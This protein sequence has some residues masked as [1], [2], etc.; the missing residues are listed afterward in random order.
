MQERVK[1]DAESTKSNLGARDIKPPPCVSAVHEFMPVLVPASLVKKLPPT[2]VSALADMPAMKDAKMEDVTEARQTEYHTFL[3]KIVQAYHRVKTE[4]PNPVM[5]IKTNDDDDEDVVPPITEDVVPRITDAG[6]WS[7]RG[8]GQNPHRGSLPPAQGATARPASEGTMSDAVRYT[9]DDESKKGE[10]NKSIMRKIQLKRAKDTKDAVVDELEVWFKAR[11]EYTQITEDDKKIG[12]MTDYGFKKNLDFNGFVTMMVHQAC[13]VGACTWGKA[14]VVNNMLEINQKPYKPLKKWLHTYARAFVKLHEGQYAVNH[15]NHTTE[16]EHTVQVATAIWLIDQ[17]RRIGT[18]AEPDEAAEPGE[19]ANPDHPFFRKNPEPAAHFDA[20]AFMAKAESLDCL[21]EQVRNTPL[22]PIKKE[23]V[24]VHLKCM[25]ASVTKKLLHMFTDHV[26]YTTAVFLGR[27]AVVLQDSI[28]ATNFCTMQSY[29]FANQGVLQT[30]KK[31]VLDD[32]LKELTLFKVYSMKIDGRLVMEQG[33]T[34]VGVTRR[35]QE[36][37]SYYE[38]RSLLHRLGVGLV[39]KLDDSNILDKRKYALKR[40]NGWWISWHELI[41]ADMCIPPVADSHFDKTYAIKSVETH[42]GKLFDDNGHE[43]V[44][45]YRSK[46]DKE[47]DK[48]GANKSS[49]LDE[50]I[51]GLDAALAG[52]TARKTDLDSGVLY[53]QNRVVFAGDVDQGDVLF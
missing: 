40:C 20:R 11:Q 52:K 4:N 35:I 53:S 34:G 1:M 51:A 21:V 43:S 31:V 13:D 18:V 28:L 3:L 14:S 12:L 23:A 41:H 32:M 25:E 8:G 26:N 17:E 30:C 38:T 27:G 22:M 16:D 15:N 42:H 24:S 44:H 50:A 7:G 29:L 19:A 49:S 2:W 10:S 37:C 9:D 48:A 6:G 45:R 47:T 36:L 39:S 33:P 46:H 5:E